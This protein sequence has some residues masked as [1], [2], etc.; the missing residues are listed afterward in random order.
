MTVDPSDS[1][2][3]PSVVVTS[4]GDSLRSL[5]EVKTTHVKENEYSVKLLENV[6]EVSLYFNCIQDMLGLRYPLSLH[7]FYLC[8]SSFGFLGFV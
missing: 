7:I 1:S 3:T 2:Y 6:Q 4:V 5:V 8:V